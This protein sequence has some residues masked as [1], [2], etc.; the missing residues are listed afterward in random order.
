MN[1]KSKL[2]HQL[3]HSLKA[4]VDI[5]SLLSDFVPESSLQTPC[6]IDSLPVTKQLPQRAANTIVRRIRHVGQARP[7][8]EL[9]FLLVL[10]L[11]SR[12]TQNK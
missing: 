5:G 8:P 11:T 9:K 7:H 4:T 3:N 10:D 2:C 1:Q 6:Q 12:A